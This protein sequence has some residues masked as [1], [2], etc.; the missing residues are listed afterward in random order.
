MEGVAAQDQQ[1]DDMEVI[2]LV[3][4][5]RRSLVYCRRDHVTE[6]VAYY[7]GRGYVV[8][9]VDVIPGDIPSLREDLIIERLHDDISASVETSEEG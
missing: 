8:R 3:R 4:D 5:G 9:Y 1:G 6:H 7:R 2:L